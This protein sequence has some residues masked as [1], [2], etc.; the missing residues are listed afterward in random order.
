[1]VSF[2]VAKDFTED[3]NTLAIPAM[4]RDMKTSATSSSTR[5]NPWSDGR[6]CL[7]CFINGTMAGLP[8]LGSNRGSI[9]DVPTH[10]QVFCLRPFNPRNVDHE[11][12]GLGGRGRS[13]PCIGAAAPGSREFGAALIG[14]RNE[15]CEIG[16]SSAIGLR[17]LHAVHI[18][19][20]VGLAGQGSARCGCED[21]R[22]GWGV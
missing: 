12:L 17:D 10:A 8:S 11:F 14:I 7:F 3:W 15:G 18:E 13:S 2:V 4:S 5:E 9:T 21:R 16:N 22:H 20:A 6:D 19:P 1:M